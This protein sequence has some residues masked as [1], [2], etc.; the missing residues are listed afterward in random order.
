MTGSFA[1]EYSPS[2]LNRIK[3]TCLTIAQILGDEMI[4]NDVV[5]VGGLVPSLLFADVEPHPA[6]GPHVGTNDLDL[7]LDIAILDDERYEEVRD[8]L[9]Q[10]GFTN[11]TSEDGALVR[12]RWRSE[13]TG[14]L[15]DFL[16]PLDPP[17]APGA[18]RLQSF[19]SD[20]AAI[21]M[22]GLDLTFEHKVMISLHG[23]DLDGAKAERLSYWRTQEEQRCL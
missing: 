20:F 1:S 18:G 21:K 12:Q 6:L 11:D 7:A 4:R 9:L 15:V 19:T 5:I 8:L 22:R 10:G 14:A 2:N 23:I 3:A 17:D 13:K 16:I